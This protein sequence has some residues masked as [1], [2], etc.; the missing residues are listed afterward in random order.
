MRRRVDGCGTA[1]DQNDWIVDCTAQL[2][3]RTLID[4]FISNLQAS[5]PAAATVEPAT[6][7]STSKAT[8]KAVASHSNG[9]STKASPPAAKPDNAKPAKEKPAQSKGK[10]GAKPEPP[11]KSK[12]P[13]T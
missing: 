2:Q 9:S 8:T 3:V 13:K 1:A 10:S 12:P 5:L 11:G 7:T 6:V 4:L